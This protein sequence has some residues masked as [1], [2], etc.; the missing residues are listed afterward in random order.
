MLDM[1]FTTEYYQT[2]TITYSKYNA[3]R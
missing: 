1:L 2:I 3:K